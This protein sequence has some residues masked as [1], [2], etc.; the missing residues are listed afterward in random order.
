M[1][2]FDGLLNLTLTVADWPGVRPAAGL[3]SN[4][5]PERL[6]VALTRTTLAG[7]PVKSISKGPLIGLVPMFLKVTVPLKVWLTR[8]Y[9]RPEAVV[10]T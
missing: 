1:A 3:V 7:S 5:D 8:L 10:V 9:V 4:G 2:L 6:T